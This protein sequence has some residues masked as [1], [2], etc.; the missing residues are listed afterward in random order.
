MNPYDTLTERQAAILRAFQ[1]AHARDR[2]SARQLTELMLH[3]DADVAALVDLRILRRVDS[4]PTRLYAGLDRGVFGT[5]P[6]GFLTSRRRLRVI[7]F[8]LIA[9][10]VAI[11]AVIR[12]F[13]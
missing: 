11:R 9:A 3:E 10:L 1:D 2:W 13:G 12:L 5:G 6:W 8:S 4:D 7:V